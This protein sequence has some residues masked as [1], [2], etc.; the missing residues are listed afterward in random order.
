MPAVHDTQLS[1]QCEQC[2]PHHACKQNEGRPRSTVKRDDVGRQ[3]LLQ[4]FS[5]SSEEATFQID[6][7]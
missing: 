5:R 6:S 7:F 1:F 3:E 2:E 4:P